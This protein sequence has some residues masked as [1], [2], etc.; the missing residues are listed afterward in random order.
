MNVRA[1]AALV[2]VLLAAA[3]PAWADDNPFAGF[4]AVGASASS[5]RDR[6]HGA[7]AAIGGAGWCA[8]KG[9]GVGERL[10]LTLDAPTVVKAIA[11]D[12]RAVEK[13]NRITGVSIA[14]DDGAP[15]DVT[16]EA[17]G[18]ATVPIAN[19]ISKLTITIT[20]ARM[21]KKSQTGKKGKKGK[22]A[23]S[24][25][26]ADL[27]DDGGRSSFVV[28]SDANAPAALAVDGPRLVA[29]YHECDARALADAIGFPFRFTHRTE[30]RHDETTDTYADAAALV[31]DQCKLPA[32]AS[33]VDCN[34]GGVDEVE[35]WL[36]GSGGDR[37]AWTLV[38]ER[39]RW[40]AT[41]IDYTS[42]RGE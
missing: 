21:G 11:L 41:G 8:K 23:A 18:R 3:S 5:T 26:T 34:P 10:T 2:V 27:T 38:W 33:D 32:I 22:P 25:L 31:A 19:A 9:L 7:A 13:S 1:R 35:C 17:D 40:R 16:I 20:G 36:V 29:A 15:L 14:L 37:G 4:H 6:T 39:G 30:G 42:G 12:T 28:T 24:C